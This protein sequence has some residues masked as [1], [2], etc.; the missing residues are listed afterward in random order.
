[1]SERAFGS[2]K[3]ANVRTCTHAIYLRPLRSFTFGRYFSSDFATLFSFL[4]WFPLRQDRPQP[5]DAFHKAKA[6]CITV[7]K[8]RHVP[9]SKCSEQNVTKGLV[10]INPET[11]EVDAAACQ[12]TSTRQARQRKEPHQNQPRT[13]R[14]QRCNTT[15]MKHWRRGQQSHATS[16]EDDLTLR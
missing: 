1:M 11:S 16:G 14:Q 5:P 2:N 12:S 13:T 4:S 8:T 9:Q 6:S 3:T 7:P 10:T 15:T